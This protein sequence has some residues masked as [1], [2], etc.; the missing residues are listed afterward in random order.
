VSESE[1]KKPVDVEV[2]GFL[3]DLDGCPAGV[4]VAQPIKSEL[5][6]RIVMISQSSSQGQRL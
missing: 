4:P 3:R 5:T 6:A 2:A 1:S